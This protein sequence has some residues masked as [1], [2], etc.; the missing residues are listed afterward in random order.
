[1]KICE[2]VVKISTSPKNRDY[3]ST[4]DN[5]NTLCIPWPNVND[6]LLPDAWNPNDALI[7]PRDQWFIYQ[8]S[9][10]LAIGMGLW[11]NWPV[12]SQGW[13][14]GG[15]GVYKV[16]NLPSPVSNYYERDILSCHHDMQTKRVWTWRK[17]VKVLTE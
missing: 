13:G 7:S 5:L 12:L 14:N 1:M 11:I 10:S 17:L 2:I 8:W 16:M 3:K 9:S 6:F 15:S 4:F